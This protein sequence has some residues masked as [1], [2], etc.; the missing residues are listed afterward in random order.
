MP[1]LLHG[2]TL[3][4]HVRTYVVIASASLLILP[5]RPPISLSLSL[6]LSLSPSHLPPP[7]S[8]LPPFLTPPPPPPLPSSSSHR[9]LF[10]F[11]PPVIRDLGEPFWLSF[12]FEA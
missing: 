7:L 11:F 4:V 2:F 6:S 5:T 9:L 10:L 1:S 12:N 8:F 3:K